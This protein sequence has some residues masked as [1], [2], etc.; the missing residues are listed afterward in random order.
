M[1]EKTGFEHQPNGEDSIPTWLWIG[2][3]GLLV[4]TIICFLIML[5]GML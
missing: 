5:A 1:Q 2:S 4:F 3:V